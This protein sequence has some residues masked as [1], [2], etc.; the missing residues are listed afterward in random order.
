VGY[1]HELDSSHYQGRKHPP[2]T[3]PFSS[4]NLG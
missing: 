4:V 2:P 1:C 3:F